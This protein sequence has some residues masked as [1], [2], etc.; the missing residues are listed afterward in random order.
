MSRD[1]TNLY[2]K[3]FNEDPSYDILME[4]LHE[5]ELQFHKWGVQDH[6]EDR[7][8]VILMEEVG[9]CCKAIQEEDPANY[10][11]E[12]VQVAAVAVAAIEAFD[13]KF[14]DGII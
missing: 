12:L 2:M 9:E 7:W 1:A 14:K 6:D 4:V 10:R 11:E 5:R 13:R 8:M 3:R